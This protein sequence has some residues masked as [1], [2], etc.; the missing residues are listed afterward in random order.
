MAER[1]ESSG[2]VPSSVRPCETACRLWP[3]PPFRRPQ[4]LAITALFP[5]NN[6][7]LVFCRPKAKTSVPLPNHSICTS[8]WLWKAA[9]LGQSSITSPTLSQPTIYGTHSAVELSACHSCSVLSIWALT[10]CWPW[11]LVLG[12]TFSPRV[13]TRVTRPASSS[14]PAFSCCSPVQTSQTT[15]KL[16]PNE[17]T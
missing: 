17:R 11:E 8:S 10:F 13:C 7:P 4:H 15:R 3:I 12:M 5:T 6:L 16:V 14:S 9:L 1:N 2:S